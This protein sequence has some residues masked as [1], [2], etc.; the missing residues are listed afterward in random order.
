MSI[1][2]TK[3]VVTNGRMSVNHGQC[4]AIATTKAMVETKNNNQYRPFDFLRTSIG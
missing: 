1:A 4:V 3:N 2:I